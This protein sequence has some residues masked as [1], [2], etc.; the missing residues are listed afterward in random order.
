MSA[1]SL[2]NPL[3]QHTKILARVL[4]AQWRTKNLMDAITLAQGSNW[5]D[6]PEVVQCL[7]AMVGAMDTDEAEALLSP[8]RTAYWALVRPQEILGRMEGYRPWPFDVRMV[9]QGTGAN[10]QW[11]GEKGPAP[12]TSLQLDDETLLRTSIR[13]FSVVST[14]LVKQASPQVESIIATEIARAGARVSDA[15]LMDPTNAGVSG[16]RPASITFG[17]PQFPCTAATVANIDDV[18]EQALN[19]VLGSGSD[20]TKAY[21]I[22]LP[23]T[24]VALSRMRGSSD[25][26]AAYPGITVKGGMFQGLPIAVSPHLPISTETGNPSIIALVDA[27]QLAVADEGDSSLSVATHA[28]VQ[29]NDDPET[30]A[31]SL[32]S[33]WQNNLVGLRAERTINWKRRA[34]DAVAVITGVTF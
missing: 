12:A 1:V 32:V 6:T 16:V 23:R 27:A 15:T 31:Q 26:P 18:C 3:Q 7:K 22:M 4:L 14:D 13:A 8:L 24:A 21:W 25:G 11:V 2:K 29:M 28:S 19:S 5:R 30:G 34:A 17:A 9:K 20:L 10:A 33:L